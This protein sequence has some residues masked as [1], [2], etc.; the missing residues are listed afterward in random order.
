[1]ATTPAHT[2]NLCGVLSEAK[3]IVNSHSRHFLALSVIFLLPLSFSLIIFPTLQLSLTKSYVV[4]TQFLVVDQ[5]DLRFYTVPLLYALFVY[6]FFLGAIATITYSTYHGFYG[7]PV[8]FFP[9]IKSLIFS[10]FPL[11]ST[12]LAAQLT[13]SLISLTFFLFFAVVIRMGENLG[14]V[15]NYSSTYF[16]AFCALIGA[17]LSLL[18]IYF[19][20]NWSLACVIVVT[21]SKWGF[22]PLWRSAYL[23]KGMKSV[24][25]SLLLL[26]GFLIG[27]WV[28]MNSNDVLC[29]DAVDGWRSWPFVL[30]LVIGTSILTLL[31]LHNTSANTVLYMYCKALHGELAIEI[32]EEFAREYVSLPFDDEKVPHVVTVFPA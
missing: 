19:L 15:I 32:A 6:I 28:W 3:R 23:V 31:L 20:V 29:F 10:F 9:A 1:M 12:T 5:T 22:E 13:L 8:K 27:F 30:Q 26:F 17:A 16:T 24:S 7:R 2:L 11:V 21:E 14:F 4:S 18:I 25:L